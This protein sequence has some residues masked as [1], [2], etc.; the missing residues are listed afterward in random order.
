MESGSGMGTFDSR[1]GRVGYWIFD[2]SDSCNASESS[3][4]IRTVTEN[5]QRSTHECAHVGRPSLPQTILEDYAN[6]DCHDS[7]PFTHIRA[8][9]RDCGRDYRIP[10]PEHRSA[11]LAC[12][13]PF[14]D[15]CPRE[16]TLSAGRS[17]KRLVCGVLRTSTRS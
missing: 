10:P 14:H 17:A 6:I 4:Q 9:K 7:Q 16:S 11:W 1:K 5:L 12:A 2:R 15:D 13:G 3:I 8:R